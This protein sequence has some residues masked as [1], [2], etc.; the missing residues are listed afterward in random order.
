MAGATGMARGVVVAYD[1]KRG[2]GF[3]QSGEFPEDV[4]VHVSNVEGRGA[5][6]T[7]QRVEFAAEVGERGLRAVRVVPGR[8]GLSPTLAAAGLMVAVL[9]AI[10]EGL[11]R[12]GLGWVAAV[13]GGIWGVTWLVYAWDKRRAGLH[14]RRVPEVVL[15]GLALVGGSP[16]AAAAML[17]LRHKT[18]KVS[19]LLK[20]AGVVAVQVAAAVAIY[21]AR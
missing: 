3:I 4:F 12:L 9:I 17:I 1:A 16:S 6:R 13:V 5:L 14:E 19:F 21:R 15:L 11:R 2:F 10:E 7:G 20:F 18:R 8:V